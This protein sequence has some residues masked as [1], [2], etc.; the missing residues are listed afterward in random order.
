M[1]SIPVLWQQVGS[2]EARERGIIDLALKAQQIG[3][4]RVPEK[5]V[6][7]HLGKRRILSPTCFGARPRFTYLHHCFT[8]DTKNRYECSGGRKVFY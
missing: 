3:M 1:D 8:L 5:K 2:C 6:V 4:R 7:N